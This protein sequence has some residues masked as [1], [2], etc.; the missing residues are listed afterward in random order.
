MKTASSKLLGLLILIATFAMGSA[1]QTNGNVAAG[2]LP[3]AV[4]ETHALGSPVAVAAWA[5]S[6]AIEVILVSPLAVIP[7]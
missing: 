4:G 6:S 2:S 1:A 5:V 7:R 3:F